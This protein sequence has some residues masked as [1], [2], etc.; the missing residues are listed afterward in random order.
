MF[1]LN[2][3]LAVLFLSSFAS[4]Q[5]TIDTLALFP[6]T[7]KF[8]NSNISVLEEVTNLGIR[9]YCDS[10]KVYLL[11]KIIVLGASQISTATPYNGTF[12]ISTGLLPEDSIL[13][14]TQ[15]ELTTGYPNWQTI[16]LDKP[17]LIKNQ[18][19]FYIT[20]LRLF[21]GIVPSIPYNNK[22]LN[23]FLLWDYPQPVW[24]ESAYFY[25]AIK[26]VLEGQTS[27]VDD[28][29]TQK[30]STYGL[31]QNYPNPFNPTTTISYSIP[32][33]SFVELK[34]FDMLGHEIQTLVSKEQSAGEY[35][36]QFD[37]SK[38]PSGMYLYSIQAGEFRASKK[39][40]LIK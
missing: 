25:F 3:V 18:K 33:S 31:S 10:S 20:G 34:V 1:R 8:I 39:L 29:G 5:T 2:L 7:T 36:V 19:C 4:A 24:Y 12:R 21:L 16:T 17:V 35:R 6:D 30:V 23:Q 38:L 27:G 22:V 13:Y 11:K 28:N 14:V 26:A 32:K 37:A 40:L 15:F 9:Y